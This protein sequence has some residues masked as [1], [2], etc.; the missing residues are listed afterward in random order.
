MKTKRSPHQKAPVDSLT[1]FNVK[2]R[3]EGDRTTYWYTPSRSWVIL[4][5]WISRCGFDPENGEIDDVGKI[6][7][8]FREV[9]D[10]PALLEVTTTPLKEALSQDEADRQILRES[11]SP[12][13]ME[14]SQEQ[15]IDSEKSKP[16]NLDDNAECEDRNLLETSTTSTSQGALDFLS[17]LEAGNENA[18]K[19][20]NCIDSLEEWRKWAKGKYAFFAKIETPA[21]SLDHISTHNLRLWET[22]GNLRCT[23]TQELKELS[24]DRVSS[25]ENLDSDSDLDLSYNDLARRFERDLSSLRVDADD[26]LDVYERA[27]KLLDYNLERMKKEKLPTI[28]PS[29]VAMLPD[30]L[31]RYRHYVKEKFYELDRSVKRDRQP[32]QVWGAEIEQPPDL[33]RICLQLGKVYANKHPTLG[34]LTM[35]FMRCFAESVIPHVIYTCHKK[36]GYDIQPPEPLTLDATLSQAGSLDSSWATEDQSYHEDPYAGVAVGKTASSASCLTLGPS[37]RL[38]TSTKRTETPSDHRT[39]VSSKDFLGAVSKNVKHQNIELSAIKRQPQAAPSKGTLAASNKSL[40]ANYLSSRLRKRRD[41][42]EYVQYRLVKGYDEDENEVP[43]SRSELKDKRRELKEA[44]KDLENDLENRKIGETRTKTYRQSGGAR[45]TENSG[46]KYSMLSKDKPKNRRVTM[47]LAGPDEIMLG[48]DEGPTTTRRRASTQSPVPRGFVD[49]GSIYQR[50]DENSVQEIRGINRT[51]RGWPDIQ[52]VSLNYGR[53]ATEPK[54]ATG[55]QGDPNDPDDDPRHR[56]RGWGRHGGRDQTGHSRDRENWDH[57]QGGRRNHNARENRGNGW[58]TDRDESP[59][60]R[61]THRQES[62]RRRG[63]GAGGED[64]DD[65]PHRHNRRGGDGDPPDQRGG[66]E[67]QTQNDGNGRRPPDRPGRGRRGGGDSPSDSPDSS[68]D[69]NETPSSDSSYDQRGQQRRGQNVVLN[70]RDLLREIRGEG[71]SDRTAQRESLEGFQNVREMER[72]YRNLPAPWNVTPL[73]TGKKADILKS[74]QMTVRPEKRYQGKTKDGSYL[75]WR[76]MVINAIHKHPLP[77]MEK[78]QQ[79]GNAVLQDKDDLRQIFSAGTY[80]PESY[81]RIIKSLEGQYGG[82]ARAYAFLRNQMLNMSHFD[83]ENL[84]EVTLTRSKVERFIECVQVNQL[85]EYSPDENKTLFELFISSVLTRRQVLKYRRRCVENGINV[86]DMNTLRSIAEWLRYEEDLLQWTDIVYNPNSMGQARRAPKVSSH[87]VSMADGSE[88]ETVTACVTKVKA[89]EKSAKVALLT[90]DTGIITDVDECIREESDEASQ[91]DDAR[92]LDTE[93]DDGDT[94]DDVEGKPDS[95]VAM[96]VLETKLP[97]C[98]YCKKSRHKIHKCEDFLK[99]AVSARFEFCK[100]DNR[101]GNC[102]SPQHGTSKCTS[103]FRC[104]HCGK[105][106]HTLLCYKGAPGLH[107]PKKSS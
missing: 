75:D 2:R 1:R 22:L 76:S 58:N 47:E 106:H 48:D 7:D 94:S 51:P 44:I 33:K 90:D 25:K 6:P 64:S 15:A 23:Q 24:R 50:T 10:V 4:A 67:D 57:G 52:N 49:A 20:K 46:N 89:K 12:T 96:A 105:K 99:L 19:L 9:L 55:G 14:K 59:R 78:I 103:T 68:H 41:E 5:T 80:T 65:S 38:S 3:V 95:D 54:V 18:R 62:G 83:L 31:R 53:V 69:E 13:E 60:R 36:W 37:N 21:D 43:L 71:N 70:A 101:C 16:P 98:G 88:P 17:D 30:I 11:L 82:K 39:K 85:G 81:R 73:T 100:R 26:M 27:I 87:K 40:Q 56:R 8:E 45:A 97:I 77:I 34:A 42:L 66:R 107:D 72:F 93:I 91:Y 32:H 104:R 79:I 92:S 84:H 28:D 35:R 102:L 63:R 74:I 29:K 86:R 61:N